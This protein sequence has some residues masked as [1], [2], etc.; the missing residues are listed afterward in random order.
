MGRYVARRLL[1]SALLVFV[2]AS[3]VAIFIHLLPGDPAYNI[4]PEGQATPERIA[5]VRQQLGLDRPLLAQYGSWIG[6]AAR[7]DL[8]A[9]PFTS[10]DVTTD[11][12]KGI[13]RP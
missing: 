10:R 3:I 9:S 8:G 6:R 13:P 1:Q 2:V 5:Q 11:V 7:G 12:G 4:V